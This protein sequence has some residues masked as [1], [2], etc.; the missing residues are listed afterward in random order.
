MQKPGSP[1]LTLWYRVLLPQA[2]AAG[3]EDVDAIIDDMALEDNIDYVV[4][5]QMNPPPAVPDTLQIAI[6][7]GMHLARLNGMDGPGPLN[8]HAQ[9]ELIQQGVASFTSMTEQ[10]RFLFWQYATCPA[11]QHYNH[12]G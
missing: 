12:R 10:E 5:Q 3:G 4:K 6:A 7:Y 1:D 8:A 11:P 9:L 2:P